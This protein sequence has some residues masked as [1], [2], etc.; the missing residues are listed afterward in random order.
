MDENGTVGIVLNNGEQSR[1]LTLPV[2]PGIGSDVRDLLS[3]R[4]HSVTDGELKVNLGPFEGALF[5]WM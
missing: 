5:E 4:C 2:E 3:G 1:T